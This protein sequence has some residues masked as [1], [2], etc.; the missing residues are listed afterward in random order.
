MS[1]TTMKKV[2]TMM[3]GIDLCMLTTVNGRGAP[4]SRPMSNNGQ[5]DYD[6]TSY[7]FT[8][9][10]SHMAKEIKKNPNVG[11]SF[12]DPKLLGDDKFLSVT[13]KA[14]LTKDKLEMEKHWTPDLNVWF[15]DGIDTKGLVMIEVKAKHIKFWEGEKED[16]LELKK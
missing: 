10:K 11:L 4:L 7:F 16:E 13:G 1:K 8:W 14:K 5:V 6:G 12:T 2:S 15:R 9:D 3:K